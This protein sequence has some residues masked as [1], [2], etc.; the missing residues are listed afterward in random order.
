MYKILYYCLFYQEL[1]KKPS[2]SLQEAGHEVALND[3]NS[4]LA[5]TS[6]SD[7]S[8]FENNNKII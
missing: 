6:S 4:V 8:L 3:P 1:L 5:D 7:P 2:R